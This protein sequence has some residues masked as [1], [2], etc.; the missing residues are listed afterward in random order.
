M[1]IH[2]YIRKN[3]LCSDQGNLIFVMLWGKSLR[4]RNCRHSFVFPRVYFFGD[5]SIE[6]PNEQYLC[7][8][9]RSRV[10]NRQYK[11]FSIPN[12]KEM[13]YNSTHELKVKHVGAY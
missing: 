8:H 11:V 6:K 7:L 12:T 5:L 10:A 4:L 3:H 13:Q 2:T 1:P 9:P